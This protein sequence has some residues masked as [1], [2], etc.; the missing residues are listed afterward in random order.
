[1]LNAPSP[2]NKPLKSLPR[3]G[4]KFIF[5]A[6][7]FNHITKFDRFR[8]ALFYILLSSRNL[9]LDIFPIAVGQCL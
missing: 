7:E 3:L 4:L 9:V 5:K 1:M 6:T 8:K 2:Q